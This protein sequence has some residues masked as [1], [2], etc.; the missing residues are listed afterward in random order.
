MSRINTNVSSLIAQTALGRSNAQLQTALSRLST[1]LRINSGKDDPAGLI[2]SENLRRDITAAN[3]A[4]SNSER[5]NQLIATADSALAQISSLLNDIRGL[6]TEAANTGVL[7]TEQIAANQLQVDSSLDAIDRIASVTT[8]QGRKIL[9]GSLDFTTSGSNPSITD[10]QILG[11]SLGS[12]GSVAVNVD[13]TAA[14]TQASLDVSALAST[15]QFTLGGQTFTLT[16]ATPGETFNNVRVDIASGAATGV[17]YAAGVLTLTLDNTNA[18]ITAAAINTAFATDGT[19]TA[20]NSGAGTINGTTTA[21]QTGITTATTIHALTFQ[22]S[23]NDGAQV[24]SFNDGATAAQ[25]ASA[26]NLVSDSTGVSAFAASGALTFTSTGYGT[27]AKVRAE[28]ISES[29]LGTFA[30]NL[31][32]TAAA[33]T[34]IAATI[35]GYTASGKGNTISLNNSA[36]NLDVTVSAGSTTDLAF[37]ITGGGALFQIGPNV[38]SGGQVRIGVGAVNTGKLGGESGRLYELKS[39]G[40]KDLSTDPTSAAKVVDESINRVTGLRGRFGAFQ[41]AT[42]DTNIASLKD[43]ISNLTDAE[44]SIR[45]ADFAKESA[46][47]TRA[48]ILVQ[49]GTAVLQIA[50]QNPQQVL[51]LLRG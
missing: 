23:G 44:S 41:H 32:G 28:V 17:T 39:G 2:A 34:D 20:T 45:D 16:A 26:V 13:I 14:A 36:L 30:A 22:L 48:Q 11:A 31:S 7:S 15:G 3:K 35:N 9:D 25:M 4:I 12:A 5:A 51:A 47:L 38:N 19:F 18:A 27:D 33:G 40:N 29:P 43:T 37:T 50:N 46:A 24:F 10:L 21:A 6:T 49:S 8:F 42:L 1:G